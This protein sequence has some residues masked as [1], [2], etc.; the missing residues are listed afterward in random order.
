MFPSPAFVAFK[1]LCDC[2]WFHPLYYFFL[3]K[4]GKKMWLITDRPCDFFSSQYVGRHFITSLFY[5]YL[6]TMQQQ[7]KTMFFLHNYDN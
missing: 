4:P 1:E 2:S 6:K 5:K 3:L 7:L